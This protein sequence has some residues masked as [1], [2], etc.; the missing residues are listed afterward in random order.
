MALCFP[1]SARDNE[2]NAT[3]PKIPPPEIPVTPSEKRCLGVGP[4]PG[5]AA[6]QM[7][8]AR[9]ADTITSADN[10]IA[11]A[12][13]YSKTHSNPMLHAARHVVPSAPLERWFIPRSISASETRIKL[14]RTDTLYIRH[15]NGITRQILLYKNDHGAR[16]VDHAPPAI[17]GHRCPVLSTTTVLPSSQFLSSSDNKSRSLNQRLDATK[18]TQS[19]SQ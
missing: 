8:G 4:D 18:L 14:V 3:E 15:A 5:K 17:A 10:A 11:S 1:G 16:L 12:T 6:K 13:L 9:L 2:V 19:F 7:N